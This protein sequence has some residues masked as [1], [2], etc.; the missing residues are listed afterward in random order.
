MTNAVAP[1]F[2]TAIADRLDASHE[3]LA[4]RWLEELK[5]VVPV[6]ETDRLLVISHLLL[7]PG[8]EVI[9]GTYPRSRAAAIPESPRR[10]P[11]W[12]RLDGQLSHQNSN[13]SACSA[14]S[15]LIACIQ[16]GLG[17]RSASRSTRV[18]R[19]RAVRATGT[20]VA[21]SEGVASGLHFVRAV[22]EP[23]RRILAGGAYG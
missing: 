17:S 5:R 4:S 15:A 14:I 11:V 3:L 16:T 12:C 2:R 8:P 10:S 23:Q 13:F 20:D 21:A 6:A 1:D 19:T 9:P 22:S 18:R 7:D